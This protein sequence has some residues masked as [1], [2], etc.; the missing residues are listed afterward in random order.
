MT[1]Y[2][3]L[4]EILISWC[5]INYKKT[6]TNISHEII[7]HNSNIKNEN[8]TLFYP[9]WH[10]KGIMYVKH[11][12]DFRIKQFYSFNNLKEIYNLNNGD[13]LKY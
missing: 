11:I 1:K 7:W 8:N 2:K 5:K 10:T 9:E 3:F 6:Y 13:Y 12:Y 4:N